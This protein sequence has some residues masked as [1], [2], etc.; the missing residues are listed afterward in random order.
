MLLR[1]VVYCLKTLT[2]PDLSRNWLK[3]TYP[4]DVIVLAV[5]RIENGVECQGEAGHDDQKKYGEPRQVRQHR[6]DYL[7]EKAS[8]KARARCPLD[9]AR[10]V[11][12]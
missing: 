3:W 4:V 8:I 9:K 12:V 2:E 6:P 7:P 11:T 1:L 10:G 5:T